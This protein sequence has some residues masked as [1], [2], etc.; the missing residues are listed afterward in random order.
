[1]PHAANPAAASST[2]KRLRIEYSMTFSSSPA[3]V[4]ALRWRRTAAAVFLESP[5]ACS[6]QFSQQTNAGSPSS[7][8]FTGGPMPPSR[9]FAKIGQKRWASASCRSAA[10][11]FASSVRTF[12]SLVVSSSGVEGRTVLAP[13]FSLPPLP[14]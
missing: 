5:F 14:P 11:S 6:T 12:R 13:V 9:L 2:M 3:F 10:P 1:M 4:P 7:T 8:S